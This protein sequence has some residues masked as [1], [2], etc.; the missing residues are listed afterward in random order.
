M[1]VLLLLAVVL[2]PVN[3]VGPET[4]V[5]ADLVADVVSVDA[6]LPALVVGPDTFVFADRVSDVVAV[7]T[8]VPI[9]V[10]TEVCVFAVRLVVSCRGTS[11][12]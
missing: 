3:V 10:G 8:T 12:A 1:A 4:F 6:A 5:F 2:V 11:C 7:V 9:A